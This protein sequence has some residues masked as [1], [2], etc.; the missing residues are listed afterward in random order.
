VCFSNAA[1]AGTACVYAELMRDTMPT[2]LQR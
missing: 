1:Y 2:Y